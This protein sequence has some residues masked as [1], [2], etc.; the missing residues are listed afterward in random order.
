MS[1]FY[2]IIHWFDQCDDGIVWHA[3]EKQERKKI[4]KEEVC[5]VSLTLGLWYERCEKF[6][7]FLFIALLCDVTCRNKIQKTQIYI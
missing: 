1:Y 5:V 6:S 4:S 3:K 2:I 7:L